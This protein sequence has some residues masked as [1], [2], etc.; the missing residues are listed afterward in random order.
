MRIT[1]PTSRKDLLVFLLRAQLDGLGQPTERQRARILSRG[2]LGTDLL[3]TGD[4]EAFLAWAE[5][6]RPLLGPDGTAVPDTL[7]E[8]YRKVLQDTRIGPGSLLRRM[9]A[10]PGPEAASVFRRNA[11]DAVTARL[12]RLN[13][14]DVQSACDDFAR[15]L[16]RTLPYTDCV[17]GDDH[18][19]LRLHDDPQT[20]PL[21]PLATA[22]M[23][24]Y[25]SGPL[26]Q[27][28]L[29]EEAADQPLG[30][31]HRAAAR[32]RNAR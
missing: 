17:V 3:T 25:I 16:S 28:P 14:V 30:A 1:R 2:D 8:L 11:A 19:L 9:A 18:V 10:D 32:P 6:V 4:T 12:A 22:G 7:R 20:A 13:K 24:A 21:H 27:R 29:T 15:L 31:Q 26:R 5:R 23:D